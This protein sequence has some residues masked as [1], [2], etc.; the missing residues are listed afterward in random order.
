M[1][2][3]NY[4]N[5]IFFPDTEVVA[6]GADG[7]QESDDDDEG[8][9]D[10]GDVG[11]GVPLVG[12]VQGGVVAAKVPWKHKSSISQVHYLISCDTETQIF[13]PV[14]SNKCQLNK[15]IDFLNSL[16]LT[17]ENLTYELLALAYILVNNYQNLKFIRCHILDT[18]QNQNNQK[19]FC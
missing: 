18:L 6:E 8:G 13:T 17:I 9:D 7:G 11:V 3:K 1:L 16:N 14:A 4:Q 15:I 2:L 5:H 12:R 10:G 19:Q